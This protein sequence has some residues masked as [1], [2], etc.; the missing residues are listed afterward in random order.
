MARVINL[1]LLLVVVASVT[2]M[3]AE[4]KIKQMERSSSRTGRIFGGKEAQPSQFP[5]QVSLQTLR[6]FHFCGGSILSSTWVCL[7]YRN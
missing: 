3:N 6:R 2:A 1:I 7:F 5:H 4:R